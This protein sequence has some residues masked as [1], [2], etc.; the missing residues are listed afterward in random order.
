MTKKLNVAVYAGTFDPIT[1]GHQSVIDSLILSGLFDRVIISVAHNS[2][3]KYMFTAKERQKMIEELYP[4]VLDNNKIIVDLLPEGKTVVNVYEEKYIKNNDS[5]CLIRGI[6]NTIDL[7]Y[8]FTL[9]DINQRLT[10]GNFPTFF[11][12][13][14]P[15]YASLSSTVVKE[16]FT[17]KPNDYK[18]VLSEMV[19]ARVIESMIDKDIKGIV[20]GANK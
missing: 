4:N 18:I 1:K 13:T 8:E 12:K 19:D 16:I 11:V 2:S 6:R 10:H 5:V 17:L 14:K 7:E 9:C 20:R 3:K 15:Q